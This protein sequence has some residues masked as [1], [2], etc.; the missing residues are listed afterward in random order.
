[1][2][3][4]R[5]RVLAV[6]CVVALTVGAFA[7]VSV[8]PTAA[9]GTT[10][11]PLRCMPLQPAFDGSW[12]ECEGFVNH[13]ALAP[14][15]FSVTDI[16]AAG[17]SPTQVGI[18]KFQEYDENDVPYGDGVRIAW[19]NSS[20]QAH[21]ASPIIVLAPGHSLMM[22]NLGDGGVVTLAGVRTTEQ[23]IIDLFLPTVLR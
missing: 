16:L 18:I 7:L 13:K 4:T 1:M 2:K 14:Y 19:T 5:G 17:G 10:G 22:F 9:Q 6:A 21:F 3:T 8:R 23:P 11:T 20:F 15:W 12:L